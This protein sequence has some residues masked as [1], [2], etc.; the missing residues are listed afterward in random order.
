[1]K[2]EDIQTSFKA[3]FK[4]KVTAIE[5]AQFYKASIAMQDIKDALDEM[6]IY[7]PTFKRIRIMHEVSDKNAPI[8]YELEGY[9]YQDAMW[10]Q[11]TYEEWGEWYTETSVEIPTKYDGKT[12]IEFKGLRIELEFIE[13]EKNDETEG[14][15]PF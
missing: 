7:V 6:G 14:C 4:M 12:S 3:K 11:D 9:Y 13:F 1:M 8:L 15:A 10:T 2:Q 5:D